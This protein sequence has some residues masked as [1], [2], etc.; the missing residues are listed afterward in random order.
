MDLGLF[1]VGEAAKRG[2]VPRLPS[3]QRLMA[4][5]GAW[6]TS[7][8][9]DLVRSVRLAPDGG[10]AASLFVDVH[11]AAFPVR[12]HATVDGA[13]DAM[14]VTS[15]VG[16]GYHTYVGRLVQRLGTATEVAWANPEG[17]AGTTGTTRFVTGSD[18]ATIE[19]EMLLWLQATLK[20]IR[21]E[22]GRGETGIQ[23][24]LPMRTR[25][26]FDG[27]VATPLGPRDDAWL[28]AAIERPQMA[29]DVW[30][31][32]SDAVDSRSI[33][34]RA[35]CLMWTEIRW[36]PPGPDELGAIDEVLELLRRAYTLDPSLDYPWPEWA[37]LMAY[38]GHENAL[39]A[40]VRDRAVGVDRPPIGYRRR[41][42]RIR[43]EGWSLT[44]PAR[45]RPVTPTSGGAGSRSVRSPWLPRR[46]D[47]C[48]RMPSWP[49]SPRTSATTRSPTTTGRS[50]SGQD[51]DRRERASESASSRGIP[52]SSAAEPRSA[53]SSTTHP[54]G[55][56]PSI[57]GARSATRDLG[58]ARRT[59]RPS[60]ASAPSIGPSALGALLASR[61]RANVSVSEPGSVGVA[62]GA[63]LGLL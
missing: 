40:T 11:P 22:R 26:T 2:L 10:G 29:V 1:V 62:V 47:R 42:V 63:G 27:A 57:C 3:G 61:R 60:A 59:P 34:G 32:W 46:P 53:S 4:D 56:G 24:S 45:S 28:A 8:G 31:W 6:L 33:L 21:E 12:L 7:D 36:R 54:T 23:L 14:A 19:R 51:H 9:H 35:L 48:R 55:S 39:A 50:W 13:V 25:F 5:A 20:S 41:P 16:P 18:R 17:G 58:M 52:P 37:E 43:H 38:R 44:V 30:P 49:G 15:A